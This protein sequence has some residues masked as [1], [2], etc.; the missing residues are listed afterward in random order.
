MK[1]ASICLCHLH[2]MNVCCQ[3]L[4]VD[5]QYCLR[6]HCITIFQSSIYIFNIKKCDCLTFTHFPHKRLTPESHAISLWEFGYNLH[7]M[8][9]LVAF[10]QYWR[11]LGLLDGAVRRD[12]GKLDEHRSATRCRQRV[13]FVFVFKFIYL[14]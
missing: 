7:L 11:S 3:I 10:C 12:N 13:F 8:I 9:I 14:F 2:C 1:G 4:H 6:F 5:N